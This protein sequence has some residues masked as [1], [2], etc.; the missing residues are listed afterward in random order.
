MTSGNTLI[1]IVIFAALITGLLSLIVGILAFINND[2]AG[3]GLCLVAAAIAFGSITNA[4][5]R[6]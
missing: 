1:G 2:W 3:T 4:L 5:L 6:R